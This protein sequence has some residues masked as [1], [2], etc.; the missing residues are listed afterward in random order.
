M[1][2]QRHTSVPRKEPARPIT[3]I[4][5]TGVQPKEKTCIEWSITLMVLL[6]NIRNNK[7]EFVSLGR[8]GH[9]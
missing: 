5:S 4:E 3:E 1:Y 7:F 6:H 8:V 2:E 9:R